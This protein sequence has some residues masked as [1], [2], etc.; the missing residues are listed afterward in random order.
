MIASTSAFLGR[1]HLH[2]RRRRRRLR[3][4]SHSSGFILALAIFCCWWSDLARDTVILGVAGILWA[5]NGLETIASLPANI[6]GGGGGGGG[7]P[8]CV[9]DF[10]WVIHSCIH[11]LEVVVG[12]RKAVGGGFWNAK[13]GLVFL[14]LRSW[15][16]F[17][18]PSGP[19]GRGGGGIPPNPDP[20]L[21]FLMP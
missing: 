17:I 9:L 21:I 15:C 13:V 7:P 10:K 19:G 8:V 6:N 11:Q 14:S 18:P 12:S 3:I 20:E 4:S 5:A 16:W 2:Q 1:C